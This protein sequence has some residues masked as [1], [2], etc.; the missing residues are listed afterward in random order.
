MACVYIGE[1][2][3]P[4][5]RGIVGFFFSANL[6]GGLLV[7]SLMGLNMNWRSISAVCTV[8]P[9]LFFISL[10]LVPESPYFLVKH[11]QLLSSCFVYRLL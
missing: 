2:S 7:T 5:M 10:L 11:G 8:E 4:P 6:T 3:T 1:I 9:I